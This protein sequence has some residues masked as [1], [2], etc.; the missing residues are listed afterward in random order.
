MDMN[1]PKDASER[2]QKKVTVDEFW[3]EP[4]IQLHSSQRL[5]GTNHSI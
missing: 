4:I 2:T 3:C 1:K 5:N